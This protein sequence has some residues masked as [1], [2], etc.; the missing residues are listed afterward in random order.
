MPETPPSLRP[1]RADELPAILDWAAA[2]GWNPGDDDAP[3]FFA[4]DPDGFFVADA[5]G[6][7][8]AAISVVNHD[9]AMAFLGLYIVDPNWRGQG[10]GRRL[11]DHALAHAGGRTVGLDGVPAQ[12]PNYA[13][14]GFVR[15]GETTRFEGTLDPAMDPAIRPVL[16]GDL[17]A[18]MAM[19]RAAQGYGRDAFLSAWLTDTATRR[20]LVLG[21]GIRG[22]VTRRTCRIGTKIG[23]LLATSRD[24]ALRLLRAAAATAGPMV[25]DVPDSETDLTAFCHD[26]GMTCSFTTARMYRGTPPKAGNAIATVA[27]LELG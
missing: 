12:Q 11:W 7:P 8:V 23:P 22:F 19:D 27:T 24:D 3:A 4:A 9:P 10:I 15:T 21:P 5:G 20:T 17:P 14:S 25:I 18:L 13:K 6:G 26:A 1:M 16:P 2:E